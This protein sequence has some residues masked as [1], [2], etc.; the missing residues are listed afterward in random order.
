MVFVFVCLFKLFIDV[1]M[2]LPVYEVKSI[3]LTGANAALK[4]GFARMK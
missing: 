2:Q 3:G 1:K 4:G